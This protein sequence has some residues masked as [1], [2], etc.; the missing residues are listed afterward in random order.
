MPLRFLETQNVQKLTHDSPLQP[1]LLLPLYF[2]I[3][4]QVGALAARPEHGSKPESCPLLPSL[5]HGDEPVPTAS[6]QMLSVLPSKYGMW[7]ALVPFTHS[8]QARARELFHLTGV[9]GLAPL[10]QSGPPAIHQRSYQAH[11]SRTLLLP[12][13]L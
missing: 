7:L 1:S 9:S 3:P 4:Q 10:G 6:H 2:R 11:L 5:V 13:S 12:L 8:T